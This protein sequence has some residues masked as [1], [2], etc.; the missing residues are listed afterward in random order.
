VRDDTTKRGLRMRGVLA[1]L[2]E[3]FELGVLALLTEVS[4]SLVC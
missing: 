1:S 3:I 4:L 2:I